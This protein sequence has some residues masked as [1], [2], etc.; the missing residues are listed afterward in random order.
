M[1]D[2]GKIVQQGTHADLMQ[3]EGLYRKFVNARK[4]AAS[5]KLWRRRDNFFDTPTSKATVELTSAL[6]F[7]VPTVY[8][9]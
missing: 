1:V 2:H 3:Q 5:W 4:I 6:D 9:F 7:F 8:T